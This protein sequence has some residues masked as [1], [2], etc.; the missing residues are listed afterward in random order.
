MKI[1]RPKTFQLSG[2]TKKEISGT[3]WL[4]KYDVC[5]LL[6][7]SV[8]K[9]DYMHKHGELPIPYVNGNGSLFWKE[10]QMMAFINKEK[11]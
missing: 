1:E 4:S 8:R 6:K 5:K 9:V 7:C 2:L 11:P 10:E 3:L